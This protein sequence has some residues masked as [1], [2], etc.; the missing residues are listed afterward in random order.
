MPCRFCGTMSGLDGYV[1]SGVHGWIK[2]KHAFYPF[3]QC[4]KF[5]LSCA[6]LHPPANAARSLFTPKV[7]VG[8]VFRRTNMTGLHSTNPEGAL[9]CKVN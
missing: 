5:Y 7:L 3:M 6:S 1:E 4:M 8:E 9:L 2:A